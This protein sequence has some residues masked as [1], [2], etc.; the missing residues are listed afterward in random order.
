MAESAQKTQENIAVL[1]KQGESEL[2]RL[3]GRV[4]MR[5]S[6]DE[7]T[8]VV[9]TAIDNASKSV[10]A[11]GGSVGQSQ[12]NAALSDW[13]SGKGKDMETSFLSAHGKELE[14]DA[15][16]MLGPAAAGNDAKI[17][18]AVRRTAEMF[19]AYPETYKTY[20]RDQLKAPLQTALEMQGLKRTAPS[21]PAEAQQQAAKKRNEG[22]STQERAWMERQM[23]GGLPKTSTPTKKP[24]EYKPEKEAVAAPVKKAEE[25]EAKKADLVAK[26]RDDAAKLQK[27]ASDKVAARKAAQTEET[28]VKETKSAEAEKNKRQ[29]VLD[30]QNKAVAEL[31]ARKAAQG[32][33]KK[34]LDKDKADKALE[35]AAARERLAQRAEAARELKQ[36]KDGEKRAKAE[37]AQAASKAQAAA[38]VQ[39]QAERAA[40]AKETAKQKAD[41]ARAAAQA[42][43]AQEA[44]VKAAKQQQQTTAQK[45]A[46]E[47]PKTAPSVSA[48][49]AKENV[50]KATRAV[51]AV[52]NAQDTIAQY[53]YRALTY[54]EFLNG[55]KKMN[56]DD[57]DYTGI[58][59]ALE[60]ARNISTPKVNSAREDVEKRLPRFAE[61]EKGLADK[62]KELTGY[63]SKG[64]EEDAKKVETEIDSL[65]GER[66][67]LCNEL[68]V[69]TLKL[70]RELQAAAEDYGKGIRD[71]AARKSAGLLPPGVSVK[72]SGTVASPYQISLPGG[73]V[74]QTAKIMLGRKNDEVVF[75]IQTP[76]TAFEDDNKKTQYLAALSDTMKQL[77][78]TRYGLANA[79]DSDKHEVDDSVSKYVG[80]LSG[81]V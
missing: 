68:K 39:E 62:E 29:A 15:R 30:K 59:G 78:Y 22:P 66:L 54:D 56:V 33:E 47:K 61:I 24:E 55:H 75:N 10:R 44:P 2:T 18:E 16:R 41:E 8:N 50:R 53:G 23:A 73:E 40:A 43:Q 57:R 80:R 77:M 19:V 74:M 72:G 49:E 35:M 12:V 69:P 6:G 21:A 13:L 81:I 67:T 79:S 38:K 51:S 58:K 7:V 20:D 52:Q 70:V 46:S 76:R 32:E 48:E 17:Q 3:A 31:A 28:R 60:A 64:K 9:R 36:Q 5:I 45:P 25:K 65:R 63:K 26:Q 14:T 71:A 27:N 1:Q 37:Q 11:Y 4:G 34:R 42:R